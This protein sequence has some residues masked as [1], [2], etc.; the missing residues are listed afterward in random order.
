VAIQ[1]H[2]VICPAVARDASP[3]AMAAARGT[4]REFSARQSRAITP[5]AAWS[6]APQQLKHRITRLT[7]VGCDEGTPTP[8]EFSHF[9]PSRATVL[10]EPYGRWLTHDFPYITA[11]LRGIMMGLRPLASKQMQPN[12]G[13]GG[14]GQPVFGKQGVGD[15]VSMH[16]GE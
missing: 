14:I 8:L 12:R 7:R 13:A 3:Q 9:C 10:G 6:M 4:E 2:N 16:H 11:A 15:R 1:K 5:S